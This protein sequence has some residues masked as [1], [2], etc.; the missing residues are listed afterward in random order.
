M[1]KPS[2]Q[3]TAETPDF[4]KKMRQPQKEEKIVEEKVFEDET[5]IIANL[6]EFNKVQLDLYGSKAIQI[7][8]NM[9]KSNIEQEIPVAKKIPNA[10]KSK[11]KSK[12]AKKTTNTPDN[13]KINKALLSFE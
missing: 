6:D 2:L 11:T 8:K 12:A 7:D 13:K 9:E 3:F 5:P 10:I 4:I 1:P